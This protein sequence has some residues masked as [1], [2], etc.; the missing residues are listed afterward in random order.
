MTRNYLIWQYHDKHKALRTINAL[1]GITDEVFKT[2]LNVSDL[3][4]IDSST[5]YAL[6]LMGRRIVC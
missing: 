6:D 1:Y 4:D 2:V 5:G 3:F